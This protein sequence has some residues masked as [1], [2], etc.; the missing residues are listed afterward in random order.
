MKNLRASQ[1]ITG[2]LILIA[3]TFIG[4]IYTFISMRQAVGAMNDASENRY[5]SYL[6]ASELRQSSDDLTRLGRTYVV[7]GD[8]SYEQQYNRVLDIRNGR[9]RGRRSTTASTGT[10]SPP[11]RTNPGRTAKPCRCKP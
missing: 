6:L 10:S 11:A 1:A 7:T 8:P 4:V 2:L 5:H 3:L 9:R